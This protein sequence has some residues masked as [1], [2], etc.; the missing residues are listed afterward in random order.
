[1]HTYSINSPKPLTMEK[2]YVQLSNG[3]IIRSDVPFKFDNGWSENIDV[4]MRL[5]N[6]DHSDPNF[7]FYRTVN[8]SFRRES[9]VAYWGQ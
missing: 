1:M 2:F 5:P 3:T 7:G 9:A 4:S 8:F 6:L